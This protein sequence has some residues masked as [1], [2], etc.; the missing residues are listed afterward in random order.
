MQGTSRQRN[1]SLVK[2]DSGISLML[3]KW[4]YTA[5][6][7]CLIV[8]NSFDCRGCGQMKGIQSVSKL[9]SDAS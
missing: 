2:Q 1:A 7:M 8:V 6:L 9:A 4:S 5:A 3:K